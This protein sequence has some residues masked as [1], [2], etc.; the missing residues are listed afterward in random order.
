M[1]LSYTSIC[2]FLVSFCFLILF[3][4]VFFY[5]SFFLY[6]LFLELLFVL[7]KLE[8]DR[9]ET[10]TERQDSFEQELV[11]RHYNQ[12][13]RNGYLKCERETGGCSEWEKGFS[14]YCILVLISLFDFFKFL[15]FYILIPIFGHH[16]KFPFIRHLIQLTV[17]PSTVM[18]RN[19]WVWFGAIYTIYNLFSFLF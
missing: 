1:L 13:T 6:C 18:G 14:S 3:F 15:S 4:H 5:F 9:R 7:H 16:A 19:K 8:R 2:F 12:K 11:F 17:G 10:R